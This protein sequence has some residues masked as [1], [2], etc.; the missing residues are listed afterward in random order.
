MLA[1]QWHLVNEH[2]PGAVLTSLTDK[3]VK[4]VYQLID[5]D[6][7]VL[8]SSV[9][10]AGLTQSFSFQWGRRWKTQGLFHSSSSAVSFVTAKY[11]A[12]IRLIDQVDW[13]TLF[14]V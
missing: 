2:F 1:V 6:G 7:E 12:R 8:V 11:N 10:G 4:S 5:A 13:K 3:G 9:A 14:N